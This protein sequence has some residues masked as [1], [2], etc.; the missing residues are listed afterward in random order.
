M[1]PEER[2][3][4]IEHSL[5]TMAEHQ[6]LML[7]RQDRHDKDIQDLR[8]MQKSMTLAITQVAKAHR[9]TDGSAPPHRGSTA[10]HRTKN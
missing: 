7:G 4:T 2:F 6:A 9:L 10:S 3:T 5:N 1:T 8:D